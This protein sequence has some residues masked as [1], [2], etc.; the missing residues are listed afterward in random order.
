MKSAMVLCGLLLGFAGL[1]QGHTGRTVQDSQSEMRSNQVLARLSYDSTYPTEE[2]SF[3]PLLWRASSCTP[4]GIIVCTGWK[5][6][7]CRNLAGPYRKR[8]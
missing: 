8:S 5:R 3:R 2:N 1:M 7:E 6:M 4:T